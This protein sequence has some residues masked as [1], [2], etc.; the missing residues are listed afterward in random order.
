MRMISVVFAAISISAGALAAGQAIAQVAPPIELPGAVSR[1]DVIAACTSTTSTQAGCQATVSA[2]F[3]YL[4]SIGVT[5]ADR[6]AEIAALAVALA[7]AD[8]P[9]EIVPVVVAALTLIGTTYATGDQA[10]AILLIA[11]TLAAGGDVETGTLI[12]SPA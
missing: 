5:G 1:A 2:Y 8:V 11:D 7:E 9:A 10:D 6:E 12:A 3:A 4:D